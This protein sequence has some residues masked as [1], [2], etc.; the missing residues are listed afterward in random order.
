MYV[1]KIAEIPSEYLAP[2]AQRARDSIGDAANTTAATRGHLIRQAVC[3]GLLRGMDDLIGEDGQVD[4]VC[5]P[6]H[7]IPLEIDNRTFTLSELLSAMVNKR[8][9]PEST[10]VE[11]EPRAK[12]IPLRKTA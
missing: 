7:E 2:L 1:P 6:H 5:D 3:D 10:V 9:V 11:L 12:T 4:I 8:S